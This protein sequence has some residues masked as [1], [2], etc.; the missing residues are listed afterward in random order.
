MKKNQFFTKVKKKWG[1]FST[2]FYTHPVKY[3]SFL[4]AGL[5]VSILFSLTFFTLPEKIQAAQ[6]NSLI[7]N[8]LPT[9]K[10]LPMEY[11]TADQTI[12]SKKAISVMFSKPHGEEYENVLSIFETAEE[13]TELNRQIYYYPIV[14]EN[15]D[16]EEKYGIDPNKVTFVF[17]KDGKEKNRVETDTLDK[18]PK[19]LIPEL[20]RLPMW[21]LGEEVAQSS[22]T[23]T[24]LS[25]DESENKLQIDGENL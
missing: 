12:Q 25:D 11:S 21:K 9:T 1:T 2:N 3:F 7:Y 20:N 23:D 15:Q 13:N 19:E 17:F 5:I 6:V 4:G 22:T 18:L 14:Y 10:L 24:A 16:L 8:Q